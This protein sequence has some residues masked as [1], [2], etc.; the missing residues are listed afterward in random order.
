MG[1]DFGVTTNGRDKRLSDDRVGT[2]AGHRT[3]ET[4]RPIDPWVLEYW[5]YAPEEEL[6]REALCTV[7]NGRFATRG[8]A[9]EHSIVGGIHYPGTYAAGV[10]NRLTTEKSGREIE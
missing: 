10:Y 6:L 5:S 1:P 8:A 2:D 4:D 3:A 7:G 9:P